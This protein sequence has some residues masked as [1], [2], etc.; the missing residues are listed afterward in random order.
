MTKGIPR[1]RAI[2]GLLPALALGACVYVPRTVEFI[3]PECK[4]VA[5]HM[6]LQEVQIAAIMGCANEGCVTLVVAAAAT[7]AVSAVISGSI[8]VAG[9]TVYWFERRGQCRRASHD[10]VSPW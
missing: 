8:V 1:R 10:T 3:D 5:R 7:A 9:N 4:V 6:V 2:F